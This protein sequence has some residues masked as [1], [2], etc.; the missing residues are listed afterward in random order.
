M[1][2]IIRN[3]ENYKRFVSCSAAIEILVCLLLLIL[4]VKEAYNF[5]VK[6][7]VLYMIAD[8]TCSKYEDATSTM[9]DNQLPKK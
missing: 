7:Y 3:P 2:N 9:F 5:Y 4:L 6:N 8:R 1:D